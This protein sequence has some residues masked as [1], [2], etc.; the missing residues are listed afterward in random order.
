MCLHV[1]T[2]EAVHTCRH[3]FFFFPSCYSHIH[4]HKQTT[5]LHEITFPDFIIRQIGRNETELVQENE[6]CYNTVTKWQSHIITPALSIRV[7]THTHTHRERA[8]ALKIW[9]R[10]ARL[11]SPCL[12]LFISVNKRSLYSGNVKRSIISRTWLPNWAL[13]DMKSV[14]RAEASRSNTCWAS[15]RGLAAYQSHWHGWWGVIKMAASDQ[16][17]SELWFPSRTEVCFICGHMYIA[18]K[19][20]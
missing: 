17:L 13:I 1:W 14:A 3:T 12:Y 4:T 20:C 9:L 5:S 6:T 2:D 16:L 10:S 15:G 8:K 19:W 7:E 11:G 18:P